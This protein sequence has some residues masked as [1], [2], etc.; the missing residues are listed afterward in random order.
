[1][2]IT[3]DEIKSWLDQDGLKYN[4]SDGGTIVTGFYENEMVN[5][6]ANDD[7]DMFELKVNKVDP[8]T[9]S[10]LKIQDHK[11]QILVLQH[12]L[13]MNYNTKFGTWEFDPS[14]GE[15]RAKVEIPLEDATMTYKQFKRIIGYCSDIHEGFDELENIM[16]TGQCP[17]DDSNDLSSLLA[18]MLA[19]MAKDPEMKEIIDKD[20]EMKEIIDGIL[21]DNSSS[22][23]KK[24]D[25][26]S[27]ED[28]I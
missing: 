5:I 20:P 21:D 1:M 8:E 7:G 3:I 16:H 24:K 27:D 13:Y 2:A 22:T 9:E 19:D 23:K 4:V 14:G 11:H 17:E 25:D 15:I 10:I 6:R 12:M 26:I 18:G 28:G